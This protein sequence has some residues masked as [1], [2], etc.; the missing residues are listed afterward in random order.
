M[1]LLVLVADMTLTT[2][3]LALESCHW[4]L[5]LGPTYIAA[6]V[7]VGAN[8]TGQEGPRVLVS[9]V[10]SNRIHAYDFASRTSSIFL[11]PSGCF[12]DSGVNCSEVW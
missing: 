6:G 2:T 12:P 9:D 1:A 5:F 8:D 7:R 4:T 11:E 3:F 10:K